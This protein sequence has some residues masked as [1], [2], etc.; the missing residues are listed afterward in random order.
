MSYGFRIIM[1]GNDMKIIKSILFIVIITFFLADLSFAQQNATDNSLDVF[2]SIVS[3]ISKDEIKD[4]PE[5]I[6]SLR[7]P[8][9][10]FFKTLVLEGN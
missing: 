1:E 2:N 4:F 3:K 7:N 10:N 6:W 8:P 5:L 9:F